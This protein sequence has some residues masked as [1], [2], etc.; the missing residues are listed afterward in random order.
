MCGEVSHF[1]TFPLLTFINLELME[2][3]KLPRGIR[4][5][6]PLNIRYVERNNWK[7]RTDINTDGEFEQFISLEW[8]I[9]AAFVLIHNYIYIYSQKT[10]QAIVS[11]WAPWDDN[12]NPES[13][14][15]RVAREIGGTPNTKPDFRDMFLMVAIVRAMIKV[16]CGV[17]VDDETIV[18]GY[19]MA[20]VDMGLKALN[21]HECNA[22]NM[23]WTLY[24]VTRKEYGKVKSEE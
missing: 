4:N 2:N 1:P 16:E 22:N 15:H 11:R 6:N 14:A 9:R 3:D 7:G 12:N 20:M 8:G 23:L 21:C 18:R 10:I 5:N 13:Y 19:T 17:R 24:K